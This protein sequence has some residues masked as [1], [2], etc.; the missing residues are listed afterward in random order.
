[1]SI[2]WDTPLVDSTEDI[3]NVLPPAWLTSG[4]IVA[5]TWVLIGELDD[6][7]YVIDVGPRGHLGKLGENLSQGDE[8][9]V[10]VAIWEDV[11]L[12]YSGRVVGDVLAPP[13]MAAGYLASGTW[14]SIEWIGGRWYVMGGPC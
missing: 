3:E 5:G 9:G 6:K 10:P 12:A 4:F 2:W 1:M 14:V 13:F 7:W 8:I 11:P